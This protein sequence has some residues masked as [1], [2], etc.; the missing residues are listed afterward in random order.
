MATALTSLLSF[1][2]MISVIF[3]V[4]SGALKLNSDSAETQTASQRAAAEAALGSLTV[5][6]A[7]AVNDAGATNVDI[8]ILNEG[9]LSYS[10]FKDWSVNVSYT[11]GSGNTILSS[12]P[13]AETLADGT[14]SIQGLYLDA[15]RSSP[16]L[17]EPS[18]VNP[19]EYLVLRIRLGDGT[20]SGTLGWAVVTPEDGISASVFFDA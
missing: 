4:L 17:I 13:Y 9:G 20:L 16:E 15:E 18:V 3:S 14:W 1:A 11:N 12:L 5:V 19:G 10:Q 6:G 2:L 7:V 8:T